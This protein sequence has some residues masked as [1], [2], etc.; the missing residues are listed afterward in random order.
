MENKPLVGGSI[1]TTLLVILGL[2]VTF[3]VI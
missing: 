3:G 1:V 2:L